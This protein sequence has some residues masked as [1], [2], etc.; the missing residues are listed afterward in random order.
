MSKKSEDNEQGLSK[1]AANNIQELEGLTTKYEKDKEMRIDPHLEKK[2]ISESYALSASHDLALS[3]IEDPGAKHFRN[4]L[5]SEDKQKLVDSIYQASAQMKELAATQQ[6]KDKLDLNTARLEASLKGIELPTS[7]QAVGNLLNKYKVNDYGIK[8]N[9]LDRNDRQKIADIIQES[10]LELSGK[11]IPAEQFP[12]QAADLMKEKAKS[13]FTAN[14]LDDFNKLVDIG[15]KSSNRDKFKSHELKAIDTS[16]NNSLEGV[17]GILEK[18]T[19]LAKEQV[20]KEKAAKEKAVEGII[21]SALENT[22]YKVSDKQKD[23]LIENLTPKVAALD[24]LEKNKESI[25]DDL[26][27]QLKSKNSFIS[28]IRGQLN[29]SSA[30]LEKINLTIKSASNKENKVQNEAKKPK[31][32]KFSKI[33]SSLAAAA[34]RAKPKTKSSKPD[35]K[36]DGQKNLNSRKKRD[37]TAKTSLN[38]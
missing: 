24:N 22:G 4:H 14:K 11:N 37:N 21:E 7:K 3:T 16:V 9:N 32:S 25:T 26:T 23:K 17:I 34:R 10:L 15:V 27:K 29:I 6:E 33:S 1:E 20:A 36:D 28:K 30:K 13:N 38:R 35:I 19:E 8:L 31:K 18:N 5:N 12:Q 2:S